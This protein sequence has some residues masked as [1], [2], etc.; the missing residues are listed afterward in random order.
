LADHTGQLHLNF[1]LDRIPV[2]AGLDALRTVRSDFAPG[3]EARGSVSGKMT[4]APLPFNPPLEKPSAKPTAQASALHGHA[5]KPHSA[6]TGPLTGSLTVDGFQLS[7]G[8][9][10][11]PVLV[12]K[13]VLEP[14]AEEDGQALI[15]TVSMPAGGTAPLVFS[16][17]FDLS[18]YR[19]AVH[20][21]AGVA[22]ARELAQ[23]AAV[24][25]AA[26]L[27]AVMG[28]P[29]AVDFIA[30][31]PWMPAEK[32]PFSGDS[33]LPGT[34]AAPPASTPPIVSGPPTTDRITG[35]VTLHNAN[36]KSDYLANH[37]LISQA[38]LHLEE[39]LMRWD[40]VAFTYGPVKG[41]ASLTLPAHCAQPACVPRFQMQF[42]QLDASA[43]EAAILGAQ[44]KV[45]LIST[46]L[47]RL[48]PAAAPVWPHLEGTVKADSLLLGPLT[49][50]AAS[51]EIRMAETGAEVTSFD[52]TLLGGSVHGSGSLQTPKSAQEKPV[53]SF[54]G[55]FAKLSPAAVGQ[56]LDQHW[57]GSVLDAS[58]KVELTG[59][60]Q[61]ELAASANGTVHFDWQRGAVTGPSVPADLV[62]F[63]RWTADAEIANGSITVKQNELRRG[64]HTAAVSAS[65]TL[66]VQ[67]KLTYAKPAE[68][69]AKR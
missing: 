3:I 62:R 42:A 61:K 9:L 2:A 69:Q 13:L 17:R 24:Q 11:A 44:E 53:Y 36:W 31:G 59:F 19:I 41:T 38:T 18:G 23:M 39:G 45:T 5:A 67:P 68:T 15:S 43:L 34:A 37:V 49:L 54:T 8:S 33:A 20:G 58:G 32:I 26:L 7:G 30:E 35:T 66:G 48:R 21:Q 65:A 60:T 46:L 64:A 63:D 57:S 28:D 27:D 51:A 50:H 10:T 52:A 56:L 40:P 25:N 6:P 14:S 16:S 55:N 22:R 47:A 1:E 4:Y 12:P 29:L